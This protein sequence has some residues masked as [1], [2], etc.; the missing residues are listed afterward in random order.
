MEAIVARP[1]EARPRLACAEWFEKHGAEPRAELIRAQLAL[2]TRVNPAQR[3]ELGRR[4]SE[5]LR[6]HGKA[7]AAEL[8]GMSASELNYSRGFIEELSL[9]EKRLA[10]H[11]EVLL[12]REPVSRLRVEVQDGKGLAQVAARP[13]FERVRWVKLT[14]KADAGA[15]ALAEAKHAG[16][17]EGLLLFGATGKAGAALG[18]SEGLAGLRTLGLTGSDA[19]DDKGVEGLAEGRLTLETLY[20]SRTGVT[21]EGVERL[22]KAKRFETLKLLAL[23]G[24]NLGDED[25]E[26]LAKSKVLVNLERLEL[27]RNEISAEGALVFRSSKALPRLKRLDLSEMWYDRRELE[28]L[29]QRFGRGLKL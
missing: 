13:W 2:C 11:G 4:V 5:L 10:E 26:A 15:A 25:A 22:A 1:D 27:A 20:L 18:K 8:P 19:F 17:L 7:W 12:T 9:P 21:G 24:D 16:R 6:E 3:L 23:N 29:R 28:P 14:G